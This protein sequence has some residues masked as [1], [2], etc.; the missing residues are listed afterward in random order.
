MFFEFL[1]GYFSRGIRI[2]QLFCRTGTGSRNLL[3]VEIFLKFFFQNVENF[4]K[5]IL[6]QKISKKVLPEKSYGRKTGFS[7]DVRLNVCMV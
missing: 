1:Y 7:G 6:V 4:Q 2:R 5:I 3:W